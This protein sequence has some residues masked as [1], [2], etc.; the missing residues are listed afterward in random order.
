MVECIMTGIVT[1]TG[2]FKYIANKNDF[3]KTMNRLAI[4]HPMPLNKLAK[5]INNKF[6]ESAPKSQ[7]LENL[8]TDL[9]SSQ[10]I[11]EHLT[12]SGKKVN[13]IVV[14]KKL[15][16]SYKIKNREVD[17]KQ[18][19]SYV[20][21]INKFKY[22]IVAL[23]WKRENGEIHLSLRSANTNILG[24]AEKLGGGGHDYAAGAPVSGNLDE[25][26]EKVLKTIDDTV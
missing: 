15:L 12:P 23:L 2:N 5:K 6:E 20:M 21:S 24:V 22:D 1:D 10:Y 16:D 13:Y 11:K 18:K 3:T 26:L 4:W 19:L 25:A 17:I 9:I 14:N 8:F 7:E